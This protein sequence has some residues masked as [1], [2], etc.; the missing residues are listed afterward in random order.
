MTSALEEW[1]ARE[2]RPSKGKLTHGNPSPS[3]G[4]AVPPDVWAWARHWLPARPHSE[5][6]GALHRPG[7]TC[8][9]CPP[10][11]HPTVSPVGRAGTMALEETPAG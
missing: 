3:L 10:A 2:G 8:T 4:D 7:S 9:P 11:G 6:W 1:V 5:K